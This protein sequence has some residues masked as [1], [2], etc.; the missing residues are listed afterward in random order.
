LR[1]ILLDIQGVLVQNGKP[2]EGAKTTLGSLRAEGLGVRFLTNV[3]THSR[4]AIAEELRGLGFDLPNEEVFSPP[5][6]AC[7]RL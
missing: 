1:G 5:I 2:I 7:A 6:A 4:R 3:T